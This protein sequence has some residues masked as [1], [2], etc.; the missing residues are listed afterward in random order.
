MR[1]QIAMTLL[2]ATLAAQAAIGIYNGPYCRQARLRQIGPP[3]LVAAA[4][5]ASDTEG[6]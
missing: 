2:I 1:E 6:D 4:A 5:P 3:E